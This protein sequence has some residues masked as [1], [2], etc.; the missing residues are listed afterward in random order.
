MKSKHT[1]LFNTCKLAIAVA[2]LSGGI[3][4]IA[5][6]NPQD[7]NQNSYKQNA[8]YDT[9]VNQNN[10]TEYN[11]EQDIRNNDENY[12]SNNYQTNTDYQ[13]DEDRSTFS[14]DES[15]KESMT[16]EKDKPNVVHFAFDS[17]ELDDEAKGK[18]DKIKDKMESGDI[19]K[20]EITIKG[21]S[22]STGDRDYNKDLSERRAESVRD[23]LAI[24]E[25]QVEQIE[26]EAHGES[27]PA[28][29]NDSREGRQ[30]NRRVEITFDGIEELERYTMN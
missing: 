5:Q 4:A 22:D 20:A 14:N 26:V 19:A 21:F 1:N 7:R 23:Y 10:S 29:D 28:V 15:E 9:R 27:N 18:L 12:R 6:E 2:A 30:E 3:H 24:D 11:S 25:S 16:S 8:Q 13:R 17:T